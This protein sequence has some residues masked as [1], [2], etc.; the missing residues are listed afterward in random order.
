VVE[1]A[2]RY[3]VV[4]AGLPGWTGTVVRHDVV[5]IHSGGGF[6]AAVGEHVHRVTQA[7]AFSDPVGDLVAV[8]ADLVVQVDDVSP[9]VWS[10]SPN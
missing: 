6:G 8:D 2:L 4:G 7:N 3:E 1:S 10:G 9:L 5:L